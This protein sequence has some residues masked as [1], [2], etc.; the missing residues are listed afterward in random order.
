MNKEIAIETAAAILA[1]HYS[2]LTPEILTKKIS[3]KNTKTYSSS[4]FA[5][6]VGYSKATV[7]RWLN[8]GIIKGKKNVLGKIRIPE[9]EI[10]KILG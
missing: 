4:E 8:E 7:H 10:S 3:G 1:E 6:V 9:S 2:E 5:E